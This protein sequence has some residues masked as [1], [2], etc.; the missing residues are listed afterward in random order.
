MDADTRSGGSLSVDRSTGAAEG[1]GMRPDGA[2]DTGEPVVVP[3]LRE[4]E[5]S[6]DPSPVLRD[7]VSSSGGAAPWVCTFCPTAHSFIHATLLVSHLIEA[8]GEVR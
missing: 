6:G 7:E 4:P 5:S 2:G 8:Y 1:R 3:P